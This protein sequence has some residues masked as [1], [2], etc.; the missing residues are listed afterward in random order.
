MKQLE[1]SFVSK[2]YRVKQI[3]IWRTKFTYEHIFTKIIIQK[4]LSAFPPLEQDVDKFSINSWGEFKTD[5][6]RLNTAGKQTNY[7]ACLLN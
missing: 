2:S 1:H 6:L 3:W 7:L 5:I 4:L